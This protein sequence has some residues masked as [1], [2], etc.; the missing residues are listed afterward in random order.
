MR[1]SRKKHWRGVPPPI[2]IPAKITAMDL[3]DVVCFGIV[4][5]RA[6]SRLWLTVKEFFA[7]GMMVE[8]QFDT[9][10]V[11]G[12]VQH[13]REME[14]EQFTADIEIMEEHRLNLLSGVSHFSF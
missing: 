9:F 8:V 1:I 2:D 12:R 11:R 5:D 6:H 10:L 3:P 7:T 4:H 13:C 14:P